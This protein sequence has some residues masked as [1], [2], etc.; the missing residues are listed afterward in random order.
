VGAGVIEFPDDPAPNGVNV[1][2]VDFGFV[3]RPGSGAALMRIDR[4]GN[5]SRVEISF[6]AMKPDVARRFVA[7]LVAARREGLRIE[8]PLLGL[9]QGAPGAPLVDGA[10][11]TGTSLPV[12]GLTPGYS[13]KE[14]YWLTLIDTAGNRYLHCTTTAVMADPSG[15]ATLTIEPPIR[16]P[17]PNEA[18]ILLAQPTVE[19]FVVEDVGWSLSLDRL[20]RFGG[21]IVIEEAA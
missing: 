5:R 17:L 12:K 2:P 4:P 21:S 11:P 7:R 16:A 8:Y 18:V 6:P 19:G 9:S 10:D 20:V 3:Q 14:G 15:D 1:M 13:I